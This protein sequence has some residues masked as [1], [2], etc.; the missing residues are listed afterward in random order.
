[1][2]SP[3]FIGAAALVLSFQAQAQ[4]YVVNAA[5]RIWR[6]KTYMGGWE[7]MPGGAKAIACNARGTLYIVGTDS[8]IYLWGEGGACWYQLDGGAKRVAVDLN[9]DPWVINDANELFQRV[10]DKWVKKPG[11]AQDIAIDGTTGDVYL[12]GT[13]VARGGFAL[14]LL[15]RKTNVLEDQ[16]C[17]GVRVA[18]F[19]GSPEVVTDEGRLIQLTGRQ[20]VEDK[21]APPAVDLAW[22]SQGK[23]LVAQ[24]TWNGT[25]DRLLYAYDPVNKKW[26][27]LEGAGVAMAVK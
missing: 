15:N 24:A 14:Y 19:N 12:I 13:K 17:G 3:I 26:F 20:W 23:F 25:P 16:N 21:S 2:K 10:R 22:G 11:S 27:Q 1:M 7:N 5:G 18:A 4:A 9:G 6:Q 8:G